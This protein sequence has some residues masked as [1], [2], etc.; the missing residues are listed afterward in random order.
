MPIARDLLDHH[1]RGYAATRAVDV[2]LVRPD[3]AN[4]RQTPSSHND[5]L[6]T[7]TWAR[8]TV[9]VCR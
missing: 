1:S 4:G 9:M 8:S 7:R 3:D 2:E 6:A 5:A